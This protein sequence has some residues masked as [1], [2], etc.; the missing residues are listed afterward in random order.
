MAEPAQRRTTA[1][2][3]PRKAL[4][5]H[6]LVDRRILSHIV[7]AA[8]I[9]PDDTVVEVGAGSGLLTEPLAAASPR[10]I[11][12]EV[13]HELAA[14]LRQQLAG[15]P[16]VTV[17]AA[18]VLALAPAELLARAGAGSPYVVMGNLPF[19]IGTA[20]VRH[21]LRAQPPPRWLLVT[22]QAE[23]AE[24]ICAGP[25]RM[26]LL[27]IE[28]QYYAQPRLLFYIPA[29]AFR[30]PPKVRAAVVRLD[31]R[32][33]PPVEVVDSEGFL[34]LVQA[35]FAAPR[36]QIRNS[37]ALG[38]RLPLDQAERLLAVAAIQRSRR[39]QT[40]ALDEWAALY[41]AYRQP[42]RSGPQ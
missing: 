16:Q 21:F 42:A 5:Q 26:S 30:P 15:R 28:F 10:L 14:R 18:D 3:H 29:R 8:E 37:L 17:V 34:R 11:A 7:A 39:P 25:G 40:L 23:V 31:V 38:L 20:I 13:D 4:G 33:R 22:L 27:S 1:Y 32:Q 41:E 35:G 2:P 9:R 24:S 12:V 6:W 36:K 19:Y